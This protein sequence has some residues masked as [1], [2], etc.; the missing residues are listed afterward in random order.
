MSRSIV[1]PL[2]V[3]SLSCAR[4][5][6]PVAE[7]PAAKPAGT[8]EIRAD[9]G[10]TLAGGG[11]MSAAVRPQAAKPL[12]MSSVVTPL[13]LQAGAAD[14]NPMQKKAVPFEGAYVEERGPC[15]GR[16]IAG[17]IGS[18]A[19]RTPICAAENDPFSKNGNG[20]PTT[21]FDAYGR[22][23]TTYTYRNPNS[24]PDNYSGY[25]RPRY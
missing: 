13:G 16:A 11:G 10:K 24:T 15:N 17:F 6:Q 18:G 19:D 9:D 20:R 23:R 5:P 3:L 12:V 1:L 8:I 2:L 25:R 4:Q 22:P 14:S 21:T 7:Q